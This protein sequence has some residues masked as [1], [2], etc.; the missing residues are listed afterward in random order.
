MRRLGLVI[1]HLGLMTK[2]IFFFF[3]FFLGGGGGGGGGVA[4]SKNDKKV[5]EKNVEVMIDPR[6]ASKVELPRFE[7]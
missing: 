5:E 3:F 6:D 7:S 2:S 4:S 1:K